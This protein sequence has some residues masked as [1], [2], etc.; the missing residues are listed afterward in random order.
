MKRFQPTLDRA[1]WPELMQLSDESR[2]AEISS[3]METRQGQLLSRIVAEDVERPSKLACAPS[4]VSQPMTVAHLNGGIY[5]LRMLMNKLI[6][7]NITQ[8]NKLTKKR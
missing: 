1:P 6:S 5:A 8:K 3:L 4:T 7:L 2:M